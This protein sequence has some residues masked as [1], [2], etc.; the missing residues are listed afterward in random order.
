MSAVSKKGSRRQEILC[1][2]D[3]CPAFL[4][5]GHYLAHKALWRSAACQYDRPPRQDER[6]LG[7]LFGAQCVE[8][9]DV[10][11][12]GPRVSRSVHGSQ[13]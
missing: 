3:Y 9:R 8:R 13:I 7:R 2:A 4:D 6:D 1:Q 12:F 11:A 5:G 10:H